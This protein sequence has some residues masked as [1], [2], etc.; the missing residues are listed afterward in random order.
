MLFRF[1]AALVMSRIHVGSLSNV[2]GALDSRDTAASS[3][4]EIR[5][6]LM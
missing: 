2:A 1:G 6:K 3:W 4:L 5:S